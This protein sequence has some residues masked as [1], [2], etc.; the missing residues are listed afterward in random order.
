MRLW[1]PDIGRLGGTDIKAAAMAGWL[2]RSPVGR[3]GGGVA[4]DG[5]DFVARRQ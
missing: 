4:F 5:P 1:L 3:D 2:N